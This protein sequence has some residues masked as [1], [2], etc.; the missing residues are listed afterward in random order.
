[1]ILNKYNEIDNQ[2]SKIFSKAAIEKINNDRDRQIAE[3]L[4]IEDKEY[5]AVAG[6]FGLSVDYVYTVKNR[7][8]KQLRGSL[9]GYN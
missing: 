7:I 1:M 3:K 9:K 5:E 2:I 4:L 6:E 8:I